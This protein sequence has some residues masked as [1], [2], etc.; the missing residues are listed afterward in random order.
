[1]KEWVGVGNGWVDDDAG[2]PISVVDDE[3]LGEKSSSSSFEVGGAGLVR[4]K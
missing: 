4:G 3:G 2:K 1:M